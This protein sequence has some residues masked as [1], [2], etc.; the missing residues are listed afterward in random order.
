MIV[1]RAA[2]KQKS[3]MEGNTSDSIN[4]STLRVF[5][6]PDLKLSLCGLAADVGDDKDCEPRPGLEQF[7]AG[8]VVDYFLAGA[9]LMVNCRIPPLSI[10]ECRSHLRLSGEPFSFTFA[11]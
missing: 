5:S 10:S 2:E 11:T 1:L 7:L 3:Q 6:H 8:R 9:G 4:R